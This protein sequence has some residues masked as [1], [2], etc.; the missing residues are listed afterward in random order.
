MRKVLITGITGFIGSHLA[1]ELISAGLEIVGLKRK[2]SNTWRNRAYQDKI[3]WVDIDDEGTYKEYLLSLN[4]DI[5]IHSAWIGV[6]ASDRDDWQQQAKNIGFLVDL[7]EV[8]KLSSVNKIIFLG[9]QAEYGTING[10]VDESYIPDPSTAYASVKLACLQI[11]KTYCKINGI[12]WV[13]LRIFSVFGERENN[14]WLIP[15]TVK[16]MTTGFEM[17]LT[18]GEQKYAYMYVKDVASI[19]TKIAMCE[20]Q[21]DIYNISS[22]ELRSIKS[23]LESI[24]EYVKPDFKL[25]FGALP[26]RENQPMHI[27]GDC[28][29]IRSQIGELQFTN[30][31]VALKRTLDYY[32]KT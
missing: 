30:F 1:E 25:D 24:K 18:G 10:K 12:S 6:E 27:E 2:E 3:H 31:N 19:I 26:Y 32:L 13:W 11:L 21:S 22:S 8:A 20:V 4:L 28:Q 16:Q 14:N 23:I 9:S 7:L 15:S 5:I 29:K 17:K